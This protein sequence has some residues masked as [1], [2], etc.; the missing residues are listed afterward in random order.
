[1]SF[2]M[3]LFGALAILSLG[4]SLWMKS[5]RR[6]V[7]LGLL[8]LSV[9]GLVV[10]TH[11]HLSFIGTIDTR[12]PQE[13]AEDRLEQEELE[14]QRWE[15][16]NRLEIALPVPEG[17]I[18]LEGS[19]DYTIPDWN[20]YVLNIPFH[21]IPERET[22]GMSLKINGKDYQ[23]SGAKCEFISFTGNSVN[24]VYP[25]IYESTDNPTGLDS[26]QYYTEKGGVGDYP[27]IYS[28]CEL[29]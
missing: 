27:F 1:M 12:S 18:V 25:E 19:G 7:S 23:A 21:G 14:R 22:P 13:I 11:A 8:A 20:Q 9:L 16:N 17:A 26:F 4:G 15:A 2:L 24:I 5:F 6:K 10:S 3:Q 29:P 28:Q